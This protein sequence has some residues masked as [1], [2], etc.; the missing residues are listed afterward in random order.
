M[1]Y[2]THKNFSKYLY[3]LAKISFMNKKERLGE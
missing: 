3:L 2:Q 1:L